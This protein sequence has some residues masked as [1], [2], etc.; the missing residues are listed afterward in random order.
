[1][2]KGK[3]KRK[4]GAGAGTKVARQQPRRN[5]KS[6]SGGKSLMGQANV[7]NQPVFAATMLRPRLMQSFGSAAPHELFPEGGQRVTGTMLCPSAVV[8]T[9]AKTYLLG[10]A[11]KS[12]V[13]VSPE[14]CKVATYTDALWASTSYL[15]INSVFFRRWICRR[16]KIRYVPL[17]GTIKADW[18][19][20]GQITMSYDQDAPV[21]A[22]AYTTA[23]TQTQLSNSRTV[24]FTPSLIAELEAIPRQKPSMDDQLNW[25]SGVSDSLAGTTAPAEV[26]TILQGGIMI[27]GGTAATSG[28]VYLGEL[29]FDYEFDLYGFTN[30]PSLANASLQAKLGAGIHPLLSFI[31]AEQQRSRDEDAKKRSLLLSVPDAVAGVVE[32]K[33]ELNPS[34]DRKA[35]TTRG[36]ESVIAPAAALGAGAL[37]GQASPAA[38]EGFVVVDG[39]TVKVVQTPQQAGWF[40]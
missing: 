14:S 36:N 6:R 7:I 35:A 27:I 21:Q 2:P 18:D 24:S 15:P 8:T 17:V 11:N 32:R 28:S 39:R 9:A 26:R 19:G 1:M 4:S 16:L 29:W 3:S 31:L 22:A 5:N 33:T 20:V 34:E 38:T 30:L 37:S 23:L 25:I 40:R 12:T 10:D 13:V